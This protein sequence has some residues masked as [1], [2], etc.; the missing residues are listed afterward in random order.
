MAAA[1]IVDL[2]PSIESL[3]NKA[4]RAALQFWLD[5]RGSADLPPLAAIAPH[6]LPR[7]LMP[8][9]SVLGVE[10]GLKRIR[11]R[12]V[13]RAIVEGIGFD[14]TGTY[15]DDAPG[16]EKAIA[17]YLACIANRRP[18]FYEGPLFWQHKEI[19]TYRALVLPFADP[20]KPI[21]RIMT[22]CEYDWAYGPHMTTA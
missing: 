20:G 13:G 6:K 4:C 18:Y 19:A 10:D 7:A 21:T 5:A 3:P 16:A 8:N 17:R 1:E 2:N 9:I 14:P 22:Y 11:F 15:A 12:I